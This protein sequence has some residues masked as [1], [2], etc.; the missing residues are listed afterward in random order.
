[1][2][3]PQLSF[4][5]EEICIS[6][7]ESNLPIPSCLV[8]PPITKNNEHFDAK[9]SRKNREPSVGKNV[10]KGEGEFSGGVGR[11]AKKFQEII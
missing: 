7:D 4:T 5:L 8:D 6:C 1:M 3:R 11:P 2:P 10:T 9:L